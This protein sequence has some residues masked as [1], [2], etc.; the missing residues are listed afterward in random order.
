VTTESLEP[1]Y[2]DKSIP[3]ILA[4]EGG[5]SNNLNDAGGETN[6][7][8]TKRVYPHLDIKNL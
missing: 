8:I 3:Y 7:G 6:F 2:F 4:H 1:T 5:Y